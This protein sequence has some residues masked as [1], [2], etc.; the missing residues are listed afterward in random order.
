MKE[1][2]EV[3]DKLNDM[4]LMRKVLDRWENEGGRIVPE[5]YHAPEHKTAAPSAVEQHAQNNAG[6]SARFG[7]PEIYGPSIAAH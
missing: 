5:P 7:Q 4:Q 6:R 2:N 3:T 1:V